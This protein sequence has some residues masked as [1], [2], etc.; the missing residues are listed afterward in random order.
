MEFHPIENSYDTAKICV[1]KFIELYNPKSV[2]DLGCN[3]GAWL[4]V[5]QENGVYN[6]TGV[7]GSNMIK[8]LMIDRSKLYCDDLETLIPYL[9]RYGL[10]LY[11]ELNR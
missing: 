1:P 9:G 10:V 11:L 7:D 5:F 6:I 2:L 8:E 4:K 3:I